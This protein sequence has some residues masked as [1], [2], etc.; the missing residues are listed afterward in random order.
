MKV[1]VV[2]HKYPPSI[3]GMQKHCF[4][5]VRNLKG[6]HEI[7]EVIYRNKGSNIGFLL[8]A[9]IKTLVTLRR[10]KDINLVYTNDGLM[11]FFLTP[12]FWFTNK[13]IVPTI[14]GLDAVFPL[15]FYQK[16]I[17]KYLNRCAAVITV[18]EP[19][20][21]ELIKRGVDEKRIRFVPNGMEIRTGQSKTDFDLG[22][23]IK[24]D[25]T[26][27][28]VL[29]SI[30]RGVKRKGFSWFVLNVLPHL[31]SDVVYVIIGPTIGDHSKVL[32]SRKWIPEKLLNTLDLLNG[33]PI[34]EL[35]LYK[36][37]QLLN[38]QDRVFHINNLNNT[39]VMAALKQSDLY[40]MPNLKVQG[41][42]EGFG[43]VALEAV[44][45]GLLCLAANVD[46][47]PS[48]IQHEKNGI[49]LP[50][51]NTEEWTTKIRELLDDESTRNKLS[52]KYRQFAISNNSSWS[53][54]TAEYE[55]IFHEIVGT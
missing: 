28:K 29:I 20:R 35:E 39:Q 22:D 25:L 45:A 4:E 50:S 52:D 24:T 5:L 32:K 33:T 43:L 27:K 47:I 31:T 17:K 12:V 13:P 11:T 21:R 7:V 14:H 38:L 34:D 8:T 10:I 26:G 51:G 19:T 15:S 9:W 16:W 36:N 46:G 3:G 54:M 41:D 2:S 23:H 44:M 49:L 37:I 30:G 1:L 40:V 53:Q 42:Y 18:S 48:A 6:N 55:K